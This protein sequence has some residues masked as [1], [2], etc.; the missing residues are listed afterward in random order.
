[1]EVT[2]ERNECVKTIFV[3]KLQSPNYLHEVFSNLKERF[4]NSRFTDLFV[5]DKREEM[6]ERER[7]IESDPTKNELDKRK[8]KLRLKEDL[9][10][11]VSSLKEQSRMKNKEQEP[12]IKRNRGMSL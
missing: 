6:K 3:E 9:K 11:S 2:P 10:F 8:D 5:Q 4:E 1:M 12:K 7:K